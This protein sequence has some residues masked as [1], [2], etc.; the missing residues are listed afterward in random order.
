MLGTFHSAGSISWVRGVR[1]PSAGSALRFT[2]QKANAMM[3]I[4][5]TNHAPVRPVAQAPLLGRSVI[6]SP[7]MGGMLAW[8]NGSGE[9][10]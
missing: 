8:G 7:G 2:N 3:T 10:R 5:A 6:G 9:F 4:N 1:G